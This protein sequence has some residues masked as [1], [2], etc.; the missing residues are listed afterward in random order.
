MGGTKA[1]NDWCVSLLDVR[2]VAHLARFRYPVA[3]PSTT[4]EILKRCLELCPE[5]APPHVR[6][7]RTPTIDD[8]RPLILEEGCGFRPARNGGI[9]LDVEWVDGASGEVKVPVVFNYG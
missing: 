2:L 5:L 1:E 7:E 4:E 6:A 9:R 3:R 8:I